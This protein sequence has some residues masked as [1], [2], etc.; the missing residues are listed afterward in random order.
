[1]DTKACN[2]SADEIDALISYHALHLRIQSPI[3]DHTKQDA[4]ERINYLNKRLK[5]FGKVAKP[6]EPILDP[7]AN[8]LPNGWGV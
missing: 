2:L 8:S 5:E 6:A 1:M 7:A 3:V 4:I